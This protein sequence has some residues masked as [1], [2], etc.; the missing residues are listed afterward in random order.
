MPGLVLQPAE[1]RDLAA[2]RTLLV[3][4]GLPAGDLGAANQHFI[5][6][7]EGGALAGCVG[8][9]VS[10]SAALLRSL[11]VVPTRQGAGVGR[12]LYRRALDEARAR[13]VSSLY[14]LTTTAERYFAREGF[15]AIGRDQVPAGVR[16][17]AEFGSLCPATA[18]CMRKPI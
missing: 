18:A 13:G 6:A 12:A 8:L 14:L 16:A 5:V 2:I 1:P 15:Q 9:E 3:E 10:G 4:L 11:A 7:R 17:S